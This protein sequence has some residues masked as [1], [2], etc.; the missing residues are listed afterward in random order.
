MRISIASSDKSG[1]SNVAPVSCDN[2]RILIV[3]D[4]ATIADL[5]AIILSGAFPGAT[6]DKAESGEDAVRLFG[7]H[8]HALVITDVNMPRMPGQVVYR[9]IEELC[10]GKIWQS[11]TV[12][13]CTGQVHN[14]EVRDIISSD[15]RHSILIKPVDPG[16]L[17]EVVKSKLGL[18]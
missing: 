2:G 7:E 15:S 6:I 18:S 8:H 1:D 3:E 9:R 5:F 11:P 4:E 10:A 13:F 14:A 16:K 12:L 17:V